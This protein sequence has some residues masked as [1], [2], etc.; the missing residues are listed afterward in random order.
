MEQPRHHESISVRALSRDVAAVLDRVE[1]ERETLLVTRNGR[2]VA[3]LTPISSRA[4]DAGTPLVGVLSPL[5]EAIL[6]RAAERAPQVVASFDDLGGW[7]EVGSAL[8]GLEGDGLLERGFA[9]YGITD[10]GR[11][12]EAVLRARADA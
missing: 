1:M 7:R 4:R 11:L 2:P 8:S 12:V 5:Q 10:Q 9:G 6:L 3:T